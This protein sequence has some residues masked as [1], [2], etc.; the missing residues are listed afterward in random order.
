[1]KRPLLVSAL[2]FALTSSACAG[3]AGGG[4]PDPGGDGGTGDGWGSHA[5]VAEIFAT[6]CTPCHGSA[7]SSCWGD[8]ESAGALTSVIQSGAMPRNGPMAPADKAAVL[9][10][11]QDGA[12]CVGS[13]P[14]GG[15][16][17]GGPLPPFGAE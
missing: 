2:L 16:G 6:Y 15:G 8:H 12:P 5:D 9:S 3:E 1:M 10:W 13:E 7:W 11:L 4:S 17:G 14:D